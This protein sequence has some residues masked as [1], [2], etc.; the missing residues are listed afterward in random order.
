MSRLA[1]LA[2]RRE[3]LDQPWRTYGVL[4]GNLPARPVAASSR[5]DSAAADLLTAV[6]WSWI[7]SLRTLHIIH[8]RKSPR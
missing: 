5:P 6:A 1:M 2:G 4:T 3:E 8:Q 7:P